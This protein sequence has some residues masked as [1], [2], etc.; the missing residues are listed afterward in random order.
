VIGD[1]ERVPLEAALKGMTTVAAAQC[2]LGA[3]A[4]S[5]SP[6]KYADLVLLESN[7]LTTDPAKLGDIKI[8]ETWVNGNKIVVPAG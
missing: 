5:L 7:P 2:G 1:N 3:R 4:G 6:G 8:S